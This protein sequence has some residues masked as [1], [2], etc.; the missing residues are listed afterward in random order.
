MLASI[1]QLEIPQQLAFVFSKLDGKNTSVSR[2]T[3]SLAGL[4]L[5]MMT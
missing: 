5:E 1:A 4:L 3:M 2:I